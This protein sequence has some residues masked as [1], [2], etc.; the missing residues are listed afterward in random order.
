MNKEYRTRFCV[1][2]ELKQGI[3]VSTEVHLSDINWLGEDP[4]LVF[5]LEL[6]QKG[7]QQN[8]E[9]SQLHF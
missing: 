3:Q 5:C 9:G 4:G 1:D 7:S 8:T 6:V 2:K